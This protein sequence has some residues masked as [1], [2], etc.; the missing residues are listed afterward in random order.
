MRALVL[1]K[2]NVARIHGTG[3]SVIRKFLDIEK[4]FQEYEEWKS[5]NLF[6][7]RKIFMT[8]Y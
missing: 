1:S 7:W 6:S 3:I 4:I 5:E 2:Y 8:E